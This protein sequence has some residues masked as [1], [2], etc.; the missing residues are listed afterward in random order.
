MEEKRMADSISKHDAYT[1]LKDLEAA[2][3]YPPVKEAHATAARRIDQIKPAD[4]Q[5]VR[6]GR[7]E[8]CKNNGIFDTHKCTLCGEKYEMY[9]DIEPTT[10][11]KYCPNC[12]ARMDGDTE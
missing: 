9:M 5:P 3:I 8:Y 10:I 1:T 7:W 11:Y 12:G 6:R 4:V 2:Y